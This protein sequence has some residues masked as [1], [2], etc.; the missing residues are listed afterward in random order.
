VVF[1]DSNREEDLERNLVDREWHIIPYHEVRQTISDILYARIAYNSQIENS[2]IFLLYTLR[3]HLPDEQKNNIVKLK[4]IEY[5]TSKVRTL[6]NHGSESMQLFLDE[7]RP[8]IEM[9]EIVLLTHYV[10]PMLNDDDKRLWID[11]INPLS[12]T[13]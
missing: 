11:T 2:K 12:Y 6:C 4:A 7:T 13:E 9:Y 8:L 1:S 5:L 10:L 3:Y